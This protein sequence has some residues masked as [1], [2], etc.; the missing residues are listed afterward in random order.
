MRVIVRRKWSTP[1]SVCGELYLDDAELP[2]AD[3]LEPPYKQ[4]G[5]KPRAIPAGTYDLTIRFSPRFNRLM[6]HVENVPG[7]EGVLIH[8][9]NFPNDTEA[10]LLVGKTHQDNFVSHSID[11]F[12]VLFKKLVDGMPAT[13]TYLDA[14]GGITWAG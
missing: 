1:A 13:I 2:E 5:S 8:W 14:V 7:F 10:C 3:T 12:N 4:D 11:E 6:P 9:G